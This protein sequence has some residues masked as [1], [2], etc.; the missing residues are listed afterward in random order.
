MV[1]SL[2]MTSDAGK[3]IGMIPEMEPNVWLQVEELQ[4]ALQGMMQQQ[5]QYGA[6]NFVGD[7]G[8][9]EQHVKNLRGTMFYVCQVFNPMSKNV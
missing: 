5:G 9:F 4:A 3:L 7:K 6:G 2:V 8:G 1:V